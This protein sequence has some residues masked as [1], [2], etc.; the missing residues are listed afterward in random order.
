MMAVTTLG[1]TEPEPSSEVFAAMRRQGS[2][3]IHA[4][5]GTLFLIVLGTGIFRAIDNGLVAS[6][7]S[8]V[9]ISFWN[10]FTGP[11]GIVMLSMIERF[12]KANPDINVS[13]QRIPWAT[14]YNKLTVAGT[15]GRGPHLFVVHASTLPRIRRAGFISNSANLY[16]GPDAINSDDFDPYVLDQVRFGDVYDGVPLD[17]HPQGLYC[18]AEMLRKAG[19]VDADGK[20]RAP[21]NKKEFMDAL[22][23]MTTQPKEANDKIWGYAL[24]NW[25]SNIRSLIPQFGGRYLDEDGNADLNSPENIEALEFLGSLTKSKLVPPPENGLGWFGYRQKKVAMVWDGVFMLGDLL[26][27]NDMEYIGAP[28]PT[29]GKQPGTMADSH[30]LCI[31]KGIRNDQ[32]FAVEKFVRFVSDNSLEWAGAGQVPARKSIRAMPG[33]A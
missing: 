33:F 4:M 7:A 13:M 18:N 6:S 8:K 1:G 32:R 14:Y 22:R 30:V 24:T 11:D 9:Q 27:L 21:R 2:F 10:G 19:I 12:N 25:G 3:S 26:R 5:L 29:I 20:P 16:S 28:V 23:A 15:D 31:R 17:I